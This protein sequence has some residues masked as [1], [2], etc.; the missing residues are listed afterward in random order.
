MHSIPSTNSDLN[1]VNDMND[2]KTPNGSSPPDKM[3]MKLKIPTN[4]SFHIS[5]PAINKNS[6]GSSSLSVKPQPT[7]PSVADTHISSHLRHLTFNYSEDFDDVMTM[8]ELD[9]GEK[10]LMQRIFLMS[11]TANH[12][13]R[14]SGSFP[15]FVVNVTAEN[16]NLHTRIQSV[17]RRHL[18]MF[19]DPE[20][21]KSLLTEIENDET[22]RCVVYT[23]THGSML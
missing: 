13:Q 21:H 18:S 4:V 11:P 22:M 16:E 6:S 20:M 14:S 3:E 1:D 7:S 12:Q 9:D 8:P 2:N 17:L 15:E 19:V 23:Q 5:P 10:D